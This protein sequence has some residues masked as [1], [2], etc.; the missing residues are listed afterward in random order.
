MS[1]S[2]GWEDRYGSFHQRMYAKY[3]GKTVRSLE[4]VRTHA[5]PER[6]RGA[7]MTRHYINPRLPH[8]TFYGKTF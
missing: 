7:I 4:T 6:L 2:F 8:L 1:T 5:I 3:A